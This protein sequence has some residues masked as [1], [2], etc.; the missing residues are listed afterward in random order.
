M[1]L[2]FTFFKG[3]LC[4]LNSTV[5]IGCLNAFFVYNGKGFVC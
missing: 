1:I 3:L 5:S 2:N 4:L